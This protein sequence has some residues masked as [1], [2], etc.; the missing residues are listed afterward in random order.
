MA[1]VYRAVQQ[2]LGREVALKALSPELFQDEDFVKRFEAEAKTLAK[3]DHP[4]ILTIYDFELTEGVA[5]LTMPLIRGGTLRDIM[6]RGP[7]DTLT[8]WRYLREI[9]DGRARARRGAADA[10]DHHRAGDRNPWLHGAGA[11]DGARCRPARRHLRDGRADV[12]DAHRPAAI[13]RRQPDGGRVLHGERDDPVGGWVEPQPAGRARPAA[14]A[15]AGER[16]EPAPADRAR[17]ARADGQACWRKTRTSAR[18][19]CASCS[20]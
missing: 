13:C 14:R 4:N 7:L 15:S 9:G 16:P 11:G 17:A 19:P 5:Y 3:L 8:A 20:G 2:P 10:P 1:V 12:R 6:K 18:R